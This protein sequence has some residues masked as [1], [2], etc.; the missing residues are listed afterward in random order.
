M[1]KSIPRS[2]RELNSH[3]I[4]Y[5]NYPWVCVPTTSVEN[6]T[7]VGK[8]DA[9]VRLLR[10]FLTS[11]CFFQK[12][13]RNFTVAFSN[14]EPAR[15]SPR[16]SSLSSWVLGIRWPGASFPRAAPLQQMCTSMWCVLLNLILDSILCPHHVFLSFCSLFRK[17]NSAGVI[18][19]LGTK[20]GEKNLGLPLCWLPPPPIALPRFILFL[21]VCF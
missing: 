6:H 11:P 4:I 8:G 20:Q 5:L 13:L 18:H 17:K 1:L 21:T 19:V 9:T 10:I 14:K 15:F 16:I 2:S 3:G 7:K 12:Y